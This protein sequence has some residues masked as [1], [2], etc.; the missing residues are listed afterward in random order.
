MQCVSYCYIIAK[1][2]QCTTT[3]PTTLNEHNLIYRAFSLIRNCKSYNTTTRTH[4]IQNAIVQQFDMLQLPNMLMY[5]ETLNTVICD[6]NSN[7]LA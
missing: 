4:Y 5:Y 2:Y 3:D 6:L 1:L 7:H